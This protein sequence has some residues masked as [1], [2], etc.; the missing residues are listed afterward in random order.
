MPHCANNGVE[1]FKLIQ[2]TGHSDLVTVLRY[3]NLSDAESQ[4]AM[5]SVPFGGTE[6]ATLENREPVVEQAQNKHNSKG[7]KSE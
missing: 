4:R 3:Y 2:W 7:P 1:P 6:D 5:L